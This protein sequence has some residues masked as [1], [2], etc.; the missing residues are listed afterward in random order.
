MKSINT[1][2]VLGDSLSKG[3][4]LDENR[5]RYYFLDECFVNNIRRA[6][7]P[8]L[9]NCAK[10]GTTVRHG[11]QIIEKNM[12]K[13][14]PDLVFIEYGGNDCDFA[15]E[16]IAKD[17][18]LDHQP[19]VPLS[20]FEEKLTQLVRIVKQYEAIPI[21][22]TL[23]PLYASNYFDWFTHGD[24]QKGES[25]LKWLKN[26]W[27]IYYWQE[28]YSSAIR[29]VAQREGVHCIEVRDAFLKDP[30]FRRL[31]CKDGIHPNPK[32][33]QLISETITKFIQQYRQSLLHSFAP[34]AP[35]AS[36]AL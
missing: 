18:S 33:H 15:W 9:I 26:V 17:P 27:V 36:P 4:T 23:P 19:K 34:A 13:H 12:E 35:Q 6:V 25:I 22:T 1:I 28:R 7:T 29:I 5:L 21:L 24:R 20:E 16:E 11:L 31:M 3:V 8:N 2:L 32:G 14:H 10:F 30:E